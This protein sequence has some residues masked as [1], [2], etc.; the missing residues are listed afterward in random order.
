[1]KRKTFLKHAGSLL[2]S[3]NLIPFGISCSETGSDRSDTPLLSD[4]NAL[5]SWLRLDGEGKVTLFTGKMEL[6]QGIRIAL[7][8]IAAEELDVDIK[9]ISI[10]IAD[11]GQTPDER[12]TA[13]SGSIEGSGMAIRQAAAGARKNLLEMASRKLQIPIQDLQVRD[14]IIQSI[15]DATINVSYWKLIAGKRLTGKITGEAKTKNPNEYLLV[16]T[17][18]LRDDIL[19]M[20]TGQ[21]SYVQDIRLPGMVHARVVRPPSYEAE[22]LSFPA[23]TIM[24]IEGVIKIIHNGSFLAVVAR[25]E[26]TAIKAWNL[27]RKESKWTAKKLLPSQVDLFDDQLQYKGEHKVVEETTGNRERVEQ[28]H[29]ATYKRPYHMHGSIGPSCALAKLESDQLT[30]WT[31]SQGVFPLRKSLSDLLNIP[32]EKIH[33]IGVP[34]SGC[35]GHNGADDVAADAAL[36]ACSL[37]NTAVRVQWMREDEHMWEPYGSAMVVKIKAALNRTGKIVEWYTDLWSDTHSTRPGGQASHL[38][39][40]QYISPKMTLKKG[41]IS[42]GA[43]RNATPFYDIPLMK[44][45]AHEYQ[46]PLRTS[47]LR[48]LGAYANIF[49]LESFVDELALLAKK[50]PLA[51]RIEHMNDPRA[52][53]VLKIVAEKTNWNKRS[54]KHDTGFGLAFAQYK[55]HA[56]YFAVIAEIELD[57]TK[58]SFKVKKLTGAIDAGQ[59]INIDGLK[60]QT[61]GGMIQSASWSLFEQVDYTSESI[62]SNTWDSY[63]IMRFED[64]PETAVTVVN[65][66]MEKPLGAGEAAQGPTS[67][68]IANAL[69]AA[70]GTRIRDLPL[71]AQK[72][73]W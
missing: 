2:I 18:V 5:D 16:G 62:K 66:P 39:A 25:E 8:Q 30:V 21:A 14:G 9:R 13:G 56:A 43:Y 35:Y 40:A 10:I 38:L 22:L 58:Q 63:R 50:D 65:H 53:E 46:G 6:G 11:T 3:F 31:H 73:K 15:K 52:I 57:R 51:F 48:S 47:A 49:A 60:N 19:N 17:A 33:A 41:G 20:A 70:T 64:A 72:I 61:E 54:I 34:G 12:Y 42:G 7:K 32:E 27:L 24:S 36:I 69:F 28:Q 68:A 23:K 37:S 44:I 4:P 67:A 59:A 1:M 55:N 29:E 45:V 71:S 26:Y